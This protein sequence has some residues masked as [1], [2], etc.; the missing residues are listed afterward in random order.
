MFSPAILSGLAGAYQSLSQGSQE[1]KQI[2]AYN[3]RLNAQA[4]E[5]DNQAEQIGQSNSIAQNFARNQMLAYRNNAQMIDS[6]LRDKSNTVAN[7]NNNIL[8]LKSEASDIRANMMQAPSRGDVLGDTINNGIATGTTAYLMQKASTPDKISPETQADM[9]HRF[10]LLGKT[11][12]TND[13]MLTKAFG[14]V[15]NKNLYGGL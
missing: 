5:K 7:N 6:I 3:N 11:P 10:N 13:N 2:Q 4:K 14:R 8:K 12:T 9:D 1:R 15:W